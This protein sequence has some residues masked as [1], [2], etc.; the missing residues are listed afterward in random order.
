MFKYDLKPAIYSTMS[1]MSIMSNMSIMNM[2]IMS[3]RLLNK[4]RR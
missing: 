3:T 4:H 2:S 1:I